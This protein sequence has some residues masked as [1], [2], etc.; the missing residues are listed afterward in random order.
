LAAVERKH[1]LQVL[2]ET[3]W[4]LGGA[5]GAAA[6]LGLAR[7]TLTNNKM[8]KLAISRRPLTKIMGN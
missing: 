3:N 2:D 6:R 5:A 8:R 7:T 1:I 4:V